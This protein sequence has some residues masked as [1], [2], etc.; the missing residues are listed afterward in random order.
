MTHAKS[1]T[2][3]RRVVVAGGGLAANVAARLFWGLAS[4]VIGL[5]RSPEVLRIFEQRLLWAFVFTVGITLAAGQGRALLALAGNRRLGPITVVSALLIASNWFVVI[6]CV[7]N[8]ELA[9]AGLGFFAAPVLTVAGGIWLL[10]ERN[11]VAVVA[12]LGLCVCGVAIYFG[13]SAAEPFAAIHVAVTSAVY[14]LLRKRFPLPSAIANTAELT[15]ALAVTSVLTAVLDGPAALLP[16][17]VDGLGFYV[18]LGAVTT[19]PML[20]YVHSLRLISVSLA[21]YVQYVT[22]TVMLAVAF[23]VF[24]EPVGGARIAGLALIWLSILMFAVG[25]R[26]A[27]PVCSGEH[28]S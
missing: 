16:P 27:R 4:W 3:D 14:A 9:S 19:L 23:F 28:A 2:A 11:S 5:A 21:G 8:G 6:W 20:L 25:A 10:G 17:E 7:R 24:H 13:D 12:S 26:A 1:A 18:L 15:V 22:P